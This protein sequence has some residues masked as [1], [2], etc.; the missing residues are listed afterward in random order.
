[1]YVGIGVGIDVVFALHAL[2]SRSEAMKSMECRFTVPPLALRPMLAFAES[3]A[4]FCCKNRLLP[5]Y[6]LLVP[7]EFSELAV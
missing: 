4:C 2:K 3:A 7:G 6:N 1:V 5:V